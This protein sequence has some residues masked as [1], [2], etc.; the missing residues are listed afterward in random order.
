LLCFV[1]WCFVMC[2]CSLSDLSSIH[3]LSFLYASLKLFHQIRQVLR[4]YK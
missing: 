1:L 4:G 2:C 3:F